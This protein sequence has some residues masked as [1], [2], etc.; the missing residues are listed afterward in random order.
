MNIE[1]KT[2]CIMQYG[3]TKHDIF[4]TFVIYSK[5]LA[6]SPVDMWVTYCIKRKI[7]YTRDPSK[8]FRVTAFYFINIA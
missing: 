4:E 8:W 2:I 7:K 6:S 5:K 3:L 1:S